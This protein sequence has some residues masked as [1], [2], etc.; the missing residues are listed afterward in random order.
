M[1]GRRL[2]R[3]PEI[4]VLP[5][6]IRDEDVAGLDVAVNDPLGAQRPA[7][8]SSA[9][10]AQELLGVERPEG[11]GCAQ[12]RQPAL[13]PHWD[14]HANTDPLVEHVAIGSSMAMSFPAWTRK[15]C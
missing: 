6:A 14:D 12:P 11:I 4:Q 7:H 1:T 3:Q 2:D 13:S 9:A 15:S 5:P 8:L 10:Q